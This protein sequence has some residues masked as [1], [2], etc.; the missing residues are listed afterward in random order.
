MASEQSPAPSERLRR[1]LVEP[2]TT[3]LQTLA[4][5]RE[6]RAFDV[7]E[8]TNTTLRA[9][10]AA[11][12]AEGLVALADEQTAGRGRRGRSWAAPPGSSLLVSA[13]IR[14]HWLQS[15][16]AFWLTK[17][18]A[19]ALAEAVEQAT[20]LRPALKWPND[21]QLGGRKL[22]GILVEVEAQPL[23]S[24]RWAVIGCG[25]N[26]NWRP[27]DDPSIT[28]AAT[29]LAEELGAP[30][31]RAAL[32]RQLL[33]A[34]DRH[35]AALRMGRREA[36]HDAWRGRLAT[37]GQPVLV[38]LGGTALEGVAEDVAADGA[39]LVRTADGRLERILAGDVS[40]RPVR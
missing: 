4:I 27:A 31:D 15:A 18:A 11:G 36:L 29:S 32:L 3:G 40:I 30:A 14:P 38:D 16:E 6:I 25:V 21:L 12:A 1:E 19:V 10:A 5:G 35:Y 23:A 34:L 9:A 22:A 17:L 8:S 20:G 28:Q 7:L 2:A 26:V 24:L 39:L 33:L 13:L 37:I